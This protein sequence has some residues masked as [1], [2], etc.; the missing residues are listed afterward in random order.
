MKRDR[1]RHP[2]CSSRQVDEDTVAAARLQRTGIRHRCR[3]VVALRWKCLAIAL[4]ITACDSPATRS[5]STDATLIA[6]GHIVVEDLA[7]RFDSAE[8]FRD[9]IEIDLGS[10]AAHAHLMEGWGDDATRSDGVSVVWATGPHASVWFHTANDAPIMVSMSVAPDFRPGWPTQEITVLLN[11]KRVATLAIDPPWQPLMA[12]LP[13][14]L[15]AIGRNVLTFEFA[16]SGTPVE[17]VATGDLEAGR[18]AIFDWIRFDRHG[19]NPPPAWRQ[20]VQSWIGGATPRATR[21]PGGEISVPKAV[22]DGQVA[23]LVAP[24]GTG[25]EYHFDA[26]PSAELVIRGVGPRES[27]RSSPT[28]A[29]A[30]AEDAGASRTVRVSAEDFADGEPLRLAL[31]PPGIKKVAFTAID[32]GDDSD[33]AAVEIES[34]LVTAPAAPPP[35]PARQQR[36]PAAELPHIFLYVIDTLRADHLGAYGY[37]LSTSPNIDAFAAD[38]VRFSRAVAQTSWTRPAV[39]SIFTGLL[40]KSHGIID[41]STGLPPTAMTIA[42]QLRDK[43]YETGGFTLNGQVDPT[44]GF[45]NGFATYETL[46]ESAEIERRAAEWIG[47]DTGAAPL[48]LFLH[49]IEPHNPYDPEPAD[50]EALA[51]DVDPNLGTQEMIESLEPIGFK[52]EQARNR[53]SSGKPL[54]PSERSGKHKEELIALYDAEIRGADARFGRFLSMLKAADLYHDSIVVLVA[55]HGEEFYD[56]GRLTH[57][58]TLYGEQL[59]I[60]LIIKFPGNWGAGRTLDWP[61][62]QIDIMPTVLDYVGLSVPDTIDGRSLMDEIDV[63][64]RSLTPAFSYVNWFGGRA[65][66]VIYGRYKL[67]QNLER[68]ALAR[69]A[70]EL[71]DLE[72]DP[73]E[74]RDLARERP[75]L[76]NFM[77]SLLRAPRP[78]AQAKLKPIETEIDSVTRERLRALGY[79]D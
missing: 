61:V 30:V 68:N 16:Y 50:R 71:Y 42:G 3:T 33:T 67:I 5:G 63:G 12:V 22:F 65:E 64:P 39:A 19:P 28:L 52:A 69:P 4:T 44:M 47:R 7:R 27:T 45:A 72:T 70:Q 59:N 78:G 43:G 49:T 57:G 62:N 51:R 31:G 46:S 55:D 75:V 60:P 15:L 18:A 32:S 48:F 1:W 73:R 74:Q 35:P 17:A 11:A 36:P 13:T 6:P 9:T 53:T 10:P 29:I 79:I 41:M 34:P 25:I 66:S 23:R 2:P 76:T 40:V 26:P 8:V 21:D 38:S 56:H 14:E 54:G 37:D 58:M 20:R 24:A 77:R